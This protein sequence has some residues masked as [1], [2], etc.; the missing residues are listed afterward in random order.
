MKIMICDCEY[1][2]PLLPYS[3]IKIQKK[4]CMIREKRK[5]VDVS[6]DAINTIG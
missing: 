4:K 2:P 5:R 6:K 3:K 1:P